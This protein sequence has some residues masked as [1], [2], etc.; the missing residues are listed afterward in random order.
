MAVELLEQ[1]QEF[2]HVT[3]PGKQTLDDK[4]RQLIEAEYLRQMGRYRWIDRGRRMDGRRRWSS[5]SGLR[6]A[7]F[8]QRSSVGGRRSSVGSQRL[9][10]NSGRPQG[11]SSD[12]FRIYRTTSRPT[13]R[14]FKKDAEK[15]DRHC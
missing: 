6:S 14:L 3:V 15:G 5:V 7:V 11:L 9:A 10:E 8:S 13:T 4:V 1:T 2:L 12:L